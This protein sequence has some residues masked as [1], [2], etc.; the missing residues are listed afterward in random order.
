MSQKIFLYERGLWVLF[1][2]LGIFAGVV[3]LLLAVCFFVQIHEWLLLP[4]TLA[5]AAEAVA[6]LM[7]S[8][9]AKR[10]YVVLADG[11]FTLGEAFGEA[12]KTYALD[13]FPYAY[14]HTDMRNQKAVVLSRKPLSAKQIRRLVHLNLVNKREDV[15]WIP[16]SFVKQGGEIQA[17][18]A[19]AYALE[20]V[21]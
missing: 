3:S 4:V 1:L 10:Q 5:G 9:C 13:A 15:V 18:F 7:Q 12:E 2:L 20:E 17:Y 11:Q 19:A 21:R 8:R 6:L 14:L 16:C